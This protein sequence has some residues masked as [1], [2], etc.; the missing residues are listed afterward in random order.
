M[1]HTHT[2][3]GLL[4]HRAQVA[5]EVEFYKHKAAQSANLLASVDAVL[6]SLG[7][8]GSDI[9]APPKRVQAAGL[10]RRGELSRVIMATL[11]ETPEGITVDALARLICRERGWET[12][13]G[14]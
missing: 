3:S 6:R 13:D 10:F 1:E 9:I 4:E 7:Y 14:K 11:R 12:D 2:I 8:E 5:G